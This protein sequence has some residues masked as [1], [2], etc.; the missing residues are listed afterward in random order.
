MQEKIVRS[1]PIDIAL[2]K[3]MH[4][5]WKMRVRSAVN[6]FSDWQEV[7]AQAPEKSDIG[8]WIQ[9]VGL[10][11][12]QHEP[13]FEM[14][15]KQHQLLHEVAYKIQ[16]LSLLGRNNEARALLNELDKLSDDFL[17][18]IDTYKTVLESYK[19]QLKEQAKP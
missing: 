18:M 8:R 19:E 16:M 4:L 1:A 14:F 6:G 9:D 15:L 3:S 17:K 12:Y 11:K 7:Y 13:V 2:V 5:T 10:W